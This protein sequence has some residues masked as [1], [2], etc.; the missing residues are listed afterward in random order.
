M[1]TVQ[2]PSSSAHFVFSASPLITATKDVA[3]VTRPLGK[4][5]VDELTPT[6]VDCLGF[7][8][9]LGFRDA[10]TNQRSAGRHYAS[11]GALSNRRLSPANGLK[12]HSLNTRQKA[13]AAQPSPSQPHLNALSTS[14]TI[15]PNPILLSSTATLR[16][17]DPESA[18]VNEDTEAIVVVV[19]GQ[20][21]TGVSASESRPL[22]ADGVSTASGAPAADGTSASGMQDGPSGQ[23]PSPSPA[24]DGG[25]SDSGGGRSAAPVLP[26]PPGGGGCHHLG[27]GLAS[28]S[29]PRSAGVGYASGSE[30]NDGLLGLHALA[31]ALDEVEVSLEL[32][33]GPL[34]LLVPLLLDSDGVSEGDDGDED[35][36]QG[37]EGRARGR[38]RGRDD[39]G[40]LN[41]GE[42]NNEEEEEEGGRSEWLK[43][44]GL[45]VQHGAAAGAE[46]EAEAG[47]ARTFI[48]G[49]GCR[50]Q[51]QRQQWLCRT[52]RVARRWG[53]RSS[54]AAAG[55][56]ARAGDFTGSPICPD[57]NQVVE[58]GP[59]TASA[60]GVGAAVGG[61]DA[62]LPWRVMLSAPTPH[63][64]E[65]LATLLLAGRLV[66]P[67]TAV[68]APLLAAA[69]REQQ[70]QQQ[71]H[72]H[73]QVQ[74]Q[75]PDPRQQ[76]PAEVPVAAAGPG[77]VA[78]AL[79]L[80]GRR[81]FSPPPQSLSRLHGSDCWR[82]LTVALQPWP[83]HPVT[84]SPS[85]LRG[86]DRIRETGPAVRRVLLRGLPG[87]M[88]VDDVITLFGN[89]LQL[90][91]EHCAAPQE[92]R[93]LVLCPNAAS[94]NALMEWSG[95][96]L[97]E[98]PL[99]ALQQIVPRALRWC[100]LRVEVQ[101]DDGLELPALVAHLMVSARQSGGAAA[102][103]AEV[104]AAT[105]SRQQHPQPQPQPPRVAGRFHPADLDAMDGVAME[106]DAAA[107]A[108]MIAAGENICTASRSLDQV[109]MAV[110]Q[111]TT[112]V[113]DLAAVKATAAPAGVDS[114]GGAV[115][116]AMAAAADVLGVAA[117]GGSGTS[118]FAASTG[119]AG[120]FW[121]P[122]AG[123]SVTGHSGGPA[124]AAAAAAAARCA[125]CPPPSLST[126]RGGGGGGC[127]ADP[128]SWSGPA[129]IELVTKLLALGIG[130]PG[131][132][133]G[134][135]KEEEEER[136]PFFRRSRKRFPMHFGRRPEE[137]EE[138][139][140]E[141]EKGPGAGE[142]ERQ[143][144]PPEAAPA[145]TAA[146]TGTAGPDAAAA[147][148]ATAA[149]AATEAVPVAAAAISP[150]GGKGGIVGVT[151]GLYKFAVDKPEIV[152]D[153]LKL[154]TN[155]LLNTAGS[156]ARP[157]SNSC[158]ILGLYFSGFESLYIYQLEPL[159]LPDSASTLLAGFSSGALFRLPRG[160]RQAVVAGLCA[161]TRVADLGGQ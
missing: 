50:Y 53:R 27:P 15:D 98:K 154:K 139:E 113:H 141:E 79:A 21:P 102:A 69:A 133:P 64:P 103:T 60:R 10:D 61:D 13:T 6:A 75:R 108:M 82:P 55:M 59:G 140:E 17:P 161:M 134:A 128:S 123:A 131:G 146:R 20:R 144:A 7:S 29:G 30:C 68:P 93:F 34:P 158:G 37:D 107:A 94:F 36:G 159:G 116:A 81:V 129:A 91:P 54:A 41:Q 83:A 160:P 67:Q 122:G 127:D 45:S 156:F 88:G 63:N 66:N 65:A 105:A 114:S 120:A 100:T 2:H 70:Q 104:A 126:G 157:F 90:P 135:E 121:G 23:L 112:A 155:R 143:G 117:P 25:G 24:A 132:G 3:I 57:L 125:C 72:P 109:P 80:H 26:G 76:Q 52:R 4:A 38:G 71:Q 84:P 119:A 130:G 77:D 47:P 19:P 51:Q 35:G 106:A 86:G 87:H 43:Q 151:S 48:D 92:R 5:V 85:G 74:G 32:P 152:T 58:E 89:G 14:Y 39:K 110:I 33:N 111:G 142:E 62:A 124:A 97:P 31:A 115:G 150:G 18:S 22:A 153:T 148:A 78:A 96:Q 118:Q 46:A 149:Q 16:Q 1:D 28:G 147:A 11:N 49:P 137:Y 12:P 95:T 145:R 9:N 44:S 101:E 42:E 138:D 136:M 73:Q 99:D 56:A 40:G 8:F